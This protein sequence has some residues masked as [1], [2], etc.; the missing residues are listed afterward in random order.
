M[1]GI[2]TTFQSRPCKMGQHSP[3]TRSE[4]ITPQQSRNK[5]AWLRESDLRSGFV[6]QLR[7]AQTSRAGAREA[8]A[9]DTRDAK[10]WQQ[11]RGP[12]GMLGLIPPSGSGTSFSISFRRDSWRCPQR[13]AT[14]RETRGERRVSRSAAGARW[15]RSASG[16]LSC[17]R[18]ADQNMRKFARKWRV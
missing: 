6:V 15:R 11:R 2:G 1:F 5:W 12:A 16:S 18:C 10:E 14:A 7:R 9:R 3:G 17:S 13:P 8:Q 4:S